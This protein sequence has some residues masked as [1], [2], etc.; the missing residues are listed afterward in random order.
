MILRKN[1][2]LRSPRS[3]RLEGRGSPMRPMA[4]VEISVDCDGWLAACPDVEALAAA[5]ARAA[6]AH[7]APAGPMV[8]GVVLTDD[9]EQRRLN[10]TYRGIDASTNVL[11]F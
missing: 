4:V 1:V 10:R 2:I 9:A 3:G 7:G 6:L 11:S 8:L 5:A